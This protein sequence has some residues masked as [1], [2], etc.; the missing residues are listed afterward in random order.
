MRHAFLF[1]GVPNDPLPGTCL[2]QARGNLVHGNVFSNVGFFGNLTN[3][4]LATETLSGGPVT[5]EPD[6]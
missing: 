6:R 1:S 4:D 5:S 2:F 3:S